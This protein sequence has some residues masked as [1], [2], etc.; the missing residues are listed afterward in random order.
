MTEKSTDN[1]SPFSAEVSETPP[2]RRISRRRFL[3]WTSLA[4]GTAA[5]AGCAVDA[6]AVEPHGFKVTRP[7]IPVP[8]LPAAWEG[9]RIAQIT[10]VHVGP[11]SSLDDAREIVRMTNALRPDL[12]AL[13]GDYVSRADSISRALVE[14]FRDLRAEWKFAVLGNHD[15]W[16]NAGEMAR[17]LESAGI[18]LLKNRH[19][20]LVRGGQPLCLA[21]VD[22]LWSSNPGPNV[23]AALAGVP[24]E[25]CRLLLCH[26]PDYAEILLPEPRVDLMLSGHTHGGQ[27]RLPFFRPLF[28]PITYKKYAAGLVQGPRCKVYVSRGLGM[29]G[30]PVRFNCRPE[31]P[32]ITL[33]RA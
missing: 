33:R 26:N 30:M 2:A 11:Y 21:G 19:H 25:T 6:L 8:N 27:V 20:L 16:A 7:E 9:L 32:L 5:A 15:Y 22:D 31:L 17:A 14:V 10:D 13:T 1:S 3:K 23:E 29:V 4:V 24:T 28:L 18:E 12:V